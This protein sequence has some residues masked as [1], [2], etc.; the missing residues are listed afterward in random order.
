MF[1]GSDR[2]HAASALFV[3]SAAIGHRPYARCPA[4]G[5]P[6]RLR[7]SGW[8]AVVGVGSGHRGDT[9]EVYLTT[10]RLVAHFKISFHGS[11]RWRFAV[12]D[13]HARSVVPPHGEATDLTLVS[14]DAV[15]P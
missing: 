4:R 8:A 5:S 13:D 9:R 11:G 6:V 3:S 14:S 1:V 10:D 2:H 12:T 15:D 7:I